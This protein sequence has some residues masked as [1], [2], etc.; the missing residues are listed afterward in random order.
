M[1][2][3]TAVQCPVSPAFSENLYVLI[4]LELIWLKVFRALIN[5]YKR[6]FLQN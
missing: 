5:I 1:C 2:L 3:Q 4:I 6:V